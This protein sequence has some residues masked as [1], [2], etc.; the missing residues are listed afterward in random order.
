MQ[1]SAIRVIAVDMDDTLLRS[2]GTVSARTLAALDAWQTGGGRTVIATGRPPR[3]I[4][5]SLPP[6]LHDAPF[7]SYNGADVR[8]AGRIIHAD[9][10]PID[11]A[12]AIVEAAQAL[13][14]NYAVG[15]EIN[16]QIYLNR[17]P[18]RPKQY[19]YTENLL[20][21]LT[22]PVA[23]ILFFPT[24][25]DADFERDEAYLEALLAALP[26]ST[27]LMRSNRFR[28][29]QLMSQ[30]ADKVTGLEVVL[31]RW[32]LGLANVAAFG[33]DVNDVEMVRRAGLGVAV[34]NAVPE[35]HA[36]AARITGTN[37]EDGVAAV[38]EELLQ[39]GTPAGSGR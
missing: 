18:D 36:V 8:M 39:V 29:I 32:D 9:L 4:A 25:P 37:D 17:A 1:D 20:D 15:L 19:V 5:P 12:R 34:A 7:I 16:D 28:L 31:G 27:R 10:I 11:D 2:D 35:V 26:A 38:I 3:S 21:I 13:L 33:D 6:L 22:E 24:R 23:K 30:S 14:L